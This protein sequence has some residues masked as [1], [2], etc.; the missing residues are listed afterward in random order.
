MYHRDQKLH[1]RGVGWSFSTLVWRTPAMTMLSSATDAQTYATMRPAPL[2]SFHQ[3]TRVAV[4]TKR[5]RLE[6]AVADWAWAKGYRKGS[7]GRTEGRDIKR[8]DGF[9]V[10]VRCRNAEGEKK[11]GRRRAGREDGMACS[12][13]RAGVVR[14]LHCKGRGIMRSSL[15]LRLSLWNGALQ[16]GSR[17]KVQ[18]SSAMSSVSRSL[19]LQALDSRP[20]ALAALGALLLR[21]SHDH[22][23]IHRLYPIRGNTVLIPIT[24]EWL[25]MT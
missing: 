18:Q 16:N 14:L 22:V 20:A 10:K 15:P 6:T 23:L 7:C 21:P 24:Y 4:E 12:C 5:L 13:R 11:V 3:R 1:S 17:S 19:A 25:Y 2:I 8:R 9:W